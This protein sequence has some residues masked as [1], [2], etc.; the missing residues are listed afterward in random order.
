[1]TWAFLLLGGYNSYLEHCAAMF[2][3]GEAMSKPMLH[4]PPLAICP[5]GA[6]GL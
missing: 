5:E 3:V 2:K 6:W 4:L 1:M